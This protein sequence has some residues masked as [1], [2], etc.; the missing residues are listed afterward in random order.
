MAN[1]PTT[2]GTPA[3]A[4]RTSSTPP[5]PAAGRENFGKITSMPTPSKPA[6][7]RVH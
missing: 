6:A 3:S 1:A 2:N 5:S 7:A 4:A